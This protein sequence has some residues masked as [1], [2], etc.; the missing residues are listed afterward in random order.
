MVELEQIW[1]LTAESSLYNVESY[2][3]GEVLQ[4]FKSLQILIELKE[5]GGQRWNRV[6]TADPDVT[7]IN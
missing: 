4:L 6:T 7:R 1:W 2:V 5:G 3:Y